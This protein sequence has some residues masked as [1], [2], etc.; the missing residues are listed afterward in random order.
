MRFLEGV[1]LGVLT[2]IEDGD[3]RKMHNA[4]FVA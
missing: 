1:A 2:R 4:D 3:I